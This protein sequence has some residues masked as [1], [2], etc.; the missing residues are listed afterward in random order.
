[1]SVYPVLLFIVRSQERARASYLARPALTWPLA[2]DAVS[3]PSWQ[4]LTGMPHVR[5]RLRQD[6]ETGAMRYEWE[7]GMEGSYTGAMLKALKKS[8]TWQG[9]N[10]RRAKPTVRSSDA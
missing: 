7:A 4:L 6:E 5:L 9:R 8:N 1:M 10:P 2:S 3:M